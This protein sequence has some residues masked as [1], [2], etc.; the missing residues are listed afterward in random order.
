MPHFLD[1]LLDK[2]RAEL[3]AAIE[4][5]IDQIMLNLRG[6]ALIVGSPK[7]TRSGRERLGVTETFFDADRSKTQRKPGEKRTPQELEAITARVLDLIK[8]HPGERIETLAARGGL[9]TKE[10]NLPIKKLIAQKAIRTRGQKR[11]T[12]YTAVGK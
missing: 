1:A 3:N 6:V 12:T 4:Q 5:Q 10:M 2:Q 11:A 7:L 9:S 8:H